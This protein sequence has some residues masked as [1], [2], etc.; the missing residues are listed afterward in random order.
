MELRGLPRDHVC[1]HILIFSPLF[2]LR[3][4]PRDWLCKHQLLGNPRT[5]AAQRLNGTLEEETQ[6]C[7]HEAFRRRGVPQ[8]SASFADCECALL[9]HFEVIISDLFWGPQSSML[10]FSLFDLRMVPYLLFYPH[11]LYYM[12]LSVW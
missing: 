7:V 11:H 3:G 5:P 12:A 2:G 10:Q 6:Q 1:K 4:L 9:K 8:N